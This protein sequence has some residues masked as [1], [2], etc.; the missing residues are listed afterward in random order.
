MI[1]SSLRDISFNKS[2]CT[3]DKPLVI[4]VVVLPILP[5]AKQNLITLL[6]MS[7]TVPNTIDIKMHLMVQLHLFEGLLIYNEDMHI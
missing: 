3:P 2:M 5:S 7:H 1:S 6:K 4:V